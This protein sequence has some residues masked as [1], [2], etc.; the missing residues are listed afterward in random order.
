MEEDRI[1]IE[2]RLTSL[3]ASVQLQAEQLKQL[4]TIK[5]ELEQLLNKFNKYE[6]RWGN[7]VMV[8]T[9]LWAV[10]ATFKDEIFKLIKVVL[11]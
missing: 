11:H 1:L 6:R 4:T 10:I 7:L 9:A 3:E 2:H 8:G 5:T